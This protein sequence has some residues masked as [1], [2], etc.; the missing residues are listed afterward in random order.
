VPQ[1]RLGIFARDFFYRLIQ[2]APAGEDGNYRQHTKHRL[3]NGGVGRGDGW[4]QKIQHR[5]A[6]QDSLENYAGYCS[7]CQPA[8]PAALVNAPGPYRHNDRQQADKFGDHAVRMLKL[9]PADHFGNLE[10]MP[11][12]GWPIR[13]GQSGIVAGDEPAGNDQQE[14]QRGNKDGKAMM[15]GVIGGRGQNC[16]LRVLIILASDSG[17]AANTNALDAER[18]N[19]ETQRKGGS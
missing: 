15:R 9:N 19:L 6:A 18:Q 1:Q 13:D 7:D 12:A 11:K 16:S 2:P 4:R 14:S 10:Q 5:Q 8:H 17:S 3:A